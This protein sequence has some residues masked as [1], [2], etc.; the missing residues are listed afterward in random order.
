MTR[1][2]FNDE[3]SDNVP[4]KK[5][6][7]DIIEELR[8]GKNGEYK[9]LKE[10]FDEIIILGKNTRRNLESK[11]ITIDDKRESDKKRDKVHKSKSETSYNKKLKKSIKIILLPHTE[12]KQ[13]LQI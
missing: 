3:F 7:K 5:N 8:K 9:R 6:L 12:Q 13:K 4:K 1:V 2:S 10:F 11:N